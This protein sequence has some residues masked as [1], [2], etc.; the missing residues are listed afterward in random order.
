ML[1]FLPRLR[2][3]AGEG[4]LPVPSGGLC[5]P[6]LPFRN[7]SGHTCILELEYRDAPSRRNAKHFER[8][9]G[10][11]LPPKPTEK[12]CRTQFFSGI[13]M[14]PR[15]ELFLPPG[16]G[17]ADPENKKI[18]AF[19]FPAALL[20]F[21]IFFPPALVRAAVGMETGGSQLVL[22]R[23]KV[24]SRELSPGTGESGKDRVMTIPG[25]VREDPGGNS[26]RTEELPWGIVPEVHVPWP[27]SKFGWQP[28][29][30]PWPPRVPGGAFPRPRSEKSYD[31][32]IHRTR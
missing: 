16:Q 19:L 4:P 25:R 6:L 1:P 31:S 8:Q 26:G 21:W 17:R 12:N 32:G 9:G 15:P 20:L 7:T 10:T 3:R 24:S 23:G 30:V 13:R 18:R 27:G 5:L 29:R 22:D 14:S 28:P 11:A 2:K